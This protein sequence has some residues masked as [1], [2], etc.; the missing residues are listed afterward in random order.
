M[1]LKT[2]KLTKIHGNKLSS[3]FN[4]WIDVRTAVFFSGEEYVVSTFIDENIIYFSKN[5]TKMLH[6]LYFSCIGDYWL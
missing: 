3:I 4:K 2:E 6:V 1:P 5:K